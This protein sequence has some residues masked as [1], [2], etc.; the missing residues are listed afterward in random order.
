MFIHLYLI[1]QLLRIYLFLPFYATFLILQCIYEL[2]RLTLQH[3][4]TRLTALC[5]VQPG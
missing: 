5:P 2:I 4:N 1:A 3:M